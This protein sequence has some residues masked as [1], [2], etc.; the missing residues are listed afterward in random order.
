MMHRA[1]LLLAGMLAACMA[2][3]QYDPVVPGHALQFPRDLGS[4]A[5]HRL[6]WWYVT[7]HLDAPRGP[8]GFQVTFFRVRN[9]AAEGQ[10]SRFAPGQ[11]LFAHAALADPKLG[12]LRHD[13]RS[14]RAGFGLAEAR[15]GATDVFIDDW[16]L[17][18][19]DGAYRTRIPAGDFTLELAMRPTQA[20]M[21]QG[22]GGFSRKGPG[23][24]HASYYYSEPQ[25]E[26]TGNVRIESES[27]AVRGVAWLDH[28]W[29][30]AMLAKDAAGW[31]W[32]G[33]NF[34][35][36]ASLMAFRIR[37]LDGHT[38]WAGGTYRDGAGTAR[39]LRPGQ[40][41]FE[42][43]RTWKSPRTG[44]TYPVAMDLRVDDRTW[45]LEPLLDDQELDARGSTGTLYWEGAVRASGASTGRGYLELTGYREKLPF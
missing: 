27:M 33:L 30:S 16:S 8:I 39:T 37:A 23:G 2:L 40:V 22:E 44:T 17:K 6:E 21:P 31:D 19:E 45:R 42:P 26:V 41:R 28:E 25:L 24:E 43:V 36:G 5:G 9:P 18:L 34:D 20:P 11:L 13:E 4:H 10:A 14:A 3:A 15:A 1:L 32:A 35:D 29:S 38:L 12:R 7:G